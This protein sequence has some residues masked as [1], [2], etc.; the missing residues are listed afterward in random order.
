[1]PP[2][3]CPSSR[4]PVPIHPLVRGSSR[5]RQAAEQKGWHTWHRNG[6]Q[7]FLEPPGSGEIIVS[8]KPDYF[9]LLGCT[10]ANRGVR[11]AAEL[12][13]TSRKAGRAMPRRG[14]RRSRAAI[15]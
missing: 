2:D 15:N 12:D 4:P 8:G 6:V 11:M 7:G 3:L 10:A 1:M 13:D 14:A 9:T 5:A